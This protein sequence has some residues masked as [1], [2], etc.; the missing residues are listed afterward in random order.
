MKTVIQLLLAA[1]ILLASYRVGH[2]YWDHYQ[3]EDAVKEAAQFSDRNKA[4]DLPARVL[5]IA[6]RMEIPLDAEHLSVSREQR[7]VTVDANYV[8][9]I[10]V[11]PGFSRDW[12]FTIHVSVLT[13]N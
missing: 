8:R 12:E 7:R 2:V 5:D 4:D 6:E 10:E 11:L 13:L 9:A 1:V 3:F